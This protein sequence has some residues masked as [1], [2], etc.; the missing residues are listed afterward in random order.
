MK[1]S[2][3][4]KGFETKQ[5]KPLKELARLVGDLHYESLEGFLLDLAVKLDKDSEADKERGRPQLAKLLKK[6]GFDIATTAMN[7]REAAYI[8]KPYMPEG[9]WV[10]KAIK[11]KEQGELSVHWCEQL[12]FEFH[13]DNGKVINEER[14]ALMMCKKDSLDVVVLDWKT[15]EEHLVPNGTKSGAYAIGNKLKG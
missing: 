10:W 13:D 5:K 4:I 11:Y 1:H 3:E 8:C 15:K 12:V 6:S 2:K 7:I 14:R 9:E